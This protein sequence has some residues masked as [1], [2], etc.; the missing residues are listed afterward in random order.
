MNSHGVQTHYLKGTK[1]LVIQTFD[2]RLLFSTN[3]KIYELD[4]VPE[5]EKTSKEFDYTTTEKPK[6]RNLPS[7]RHPWKR[8]TFLKFRNHKLTENMLAC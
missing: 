4:P 2:N 1:G 8:D 6:K 5:H 7:P 3:E